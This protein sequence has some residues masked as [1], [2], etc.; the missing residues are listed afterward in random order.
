VQFVFFLGM[1]SLAIGV[2]LID[3]VKP[4]ILFNPY[5]L[6]LIM[7]SLIALAGYVTLKLKPTKT[8]SNW[9]STWSRKKI[10]ILSG[11]AIAVVIGIPLA[12]RGVQYLNDQ[13]LLEEANTQFQI[14]A[15]SLASQGQIENTL[16]ELERQLSKLR[17]KYIEDPPDYLIQVWIFADVT[18]LQAETSAPDWSDAFVSITPGESPIIYILVEPEGERFDKT[19]PTARPAHEITHVVTY[20]AL[21]LQ[22]MT[23]IPRFFHEGLA[24]YESLKGLPNLLYRLTIR[25]F[26]FTL[27]PSLVLQDEPPYL[28]RGATQEYVDIFYAL[29]YEFARYLADEYGEERLWRIVELVGS[30]IDFDAAFVNVTGRQYLD[31]Y[32]EFS[33]DWLCA[34]VIA[35]YHEWREQH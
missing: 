24:Q 17:S 13:R 6:S 8:R 9:L 30:G 5:I 1:F 20:E 12:V 35:K 32:R 11:L 21:E 33:Q 19:A 16:I 26:L 15:S 31:A 3:Q 22:S 10:L 7:L 14:E 2:V 27:D 18:E 28:Y 25:I 29:S 23:L 4:A 34:P